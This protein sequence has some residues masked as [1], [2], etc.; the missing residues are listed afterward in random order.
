MKISFETFE[1]RKKYPFTISGYT[2]LTQ[3]VIYL[4]IEHEGYTGVGEA[5]PGYYFN[6]TIDDVLAFYASLVPDF[7][8]FSDISDRQ[9][10]MDFVEKK[11]PGL[12]AAKAGIDVALNDLYGKILGKPCYQLFG[13]DPDKMPVTSFTIGM[14]TPEVI[15]K[16]VS[17]ATEFKLLKIK[18]GG[19]NDRGIIEA[20]RSVSDQPLCVDANQ[21]W[22]DR[23]EAIDMIHWLKEQGT[24]FI[25]QPMPVA[26]RDDNAWVTEHSP[27][28]VVADEAVQR[29]VDVES[30][31][32]VYHG[33]NIKMSKCTGMLEG[34]KMVQKARSLGLKLMIGCMSESSVGILGAAAIAP[35]CD[36]VDLDSSWLIANNPYHDPELREG[37]IILSDAPG[38]GLRKK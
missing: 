19:E 32:G 11:R 33:I 34:Y 1:L 17:E 37:K 18:L 35:L 15:R 29:L 16:K 38:L 14:D 2:M 22:T 20:I 21:G 5:S 28:P 7:A 4:T 24:T 10:I 12:T 27:L 30:A 25:E 9:S 31:K 23:Q 8:K 13:A 26:Q 6:E 36:W 3:S